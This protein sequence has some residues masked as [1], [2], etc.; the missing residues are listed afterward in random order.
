MTA[1]L[2]L[3]DGKKTYIVA[4]L[5]GLAAAAAMLGFHVPDF[6]WPPLSA[7]GLGAVRDA[8]GKLNLKGL[9]RCPFSNRL[10]WSVP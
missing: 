3:L 8:I 2:A 7:A 9:P 4:A 5:T 6:V 1:I 10:P